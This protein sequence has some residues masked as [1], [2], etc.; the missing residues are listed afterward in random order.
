MPKVTI[1]ITT[2]NAM[3]TLPAAIQSAYAQ[4]HQ[5]IEVVVADDL[6]TD[7][8]RE[9]LLQLQGQHPALR[10]VL[11]ETNQGVAGARNSLIHAATGAYVA[12]FDDDDV[13]DCTRVAKQLQAI[14]AAESAF[15]DDALVICHTARTQVYP[16]GSRVYCATQVA[17]PPPHGAAVA[18]RILLGRPLP[19]CRHG[20][21]A[22]CSQM[23][24]TST[25]KKLGGFD[26]AL[27][28]GED[29]D[30]NIRLA[31]AGG[32]FIGLPEPLVTQAMTLRQ[33]KGWVAEH[34]FTMHILQK[35]SAVVAS[36]GFATFAPAWA[37]MK[38]A[39]LQGRY[40]SFIKQALLV[41]C[42]HPWQ[43]AQR[44]GWTLP[45]MLDNLK[46]G[47]FRRGLNCL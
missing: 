8:T 25:Y 44:I 27:R 40:A 38:L 37:T 3:A 18:L 6:S 32:Y 23:A 35:H 42:R 28:R 13:S 5:D 17:N 31:L 22:T 21:M 47:R 26:A 14:N 19:Q 36:A 24:R 45:N 34:N 7:G 43:T 30:F 10:V 33:D 41:A 12:F 15:G 39:F 2:Y 46:I 16:D 4:T 9:L 1:G 29:T 20:A 11:H